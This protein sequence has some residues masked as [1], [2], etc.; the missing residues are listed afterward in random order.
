MVTSPAP[1]GGAQR[2]ELAWQCAHQQGVL[3]DALSAWVDAEQQVVA[4]RRGGPCVA[5]GAL[6]AHLDACSTDLA[7]LQTEAATSCKAAAA[8]GAC[9]ECQLSELCPEV[10]ALSE[11]YPASKRA[12]LG[13]T[14]DRDAMST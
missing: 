1:P 8:G 3:W 9:G 14:Q 10:R 6:R 11:H 2:V 13:A 7:L 4:G 12:D 5:M